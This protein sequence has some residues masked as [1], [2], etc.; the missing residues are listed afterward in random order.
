METNF[1]MDGMGEMVQVAMLAY[2]SGN[3]SDGEP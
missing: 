1:S 2:G 3:A